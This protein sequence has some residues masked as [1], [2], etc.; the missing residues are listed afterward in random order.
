MS[1][2]KLTKHF[3]LWLFLAMAVYFAAITLYKRWY[4]I[5][6]LRHVSDTYSKYEGVD[7]VSAAFMKGYR[8]NDTI[9]VDVTLLKADNDSVYMALLS[10][11][12]RVI[13][14]FDTLPMLHREYST[15]TW[16]APKADYTKTTDTTNCINNDIFSSHLSRRVIVIFHIETKEQ[17]DVI[18]Q[19]IFDKAIEYSI[20]QQK[21][22]QNQI[23]KNH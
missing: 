11:F 12:N 18:S 3:W 15:I 10:D 16:K 4:D 17:Y 23:L 20:E 19:Y 7:G 1:N 5:F 22:N 2:T 6:P 21:H 14:Y 9:S 13:P 8:I